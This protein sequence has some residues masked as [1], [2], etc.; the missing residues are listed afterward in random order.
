[1]ASRADSK[2]LMQ[3]W[4]SE[5]SG[6]N[7]YIMFSLNS[8][9]ESWAKRNVRW[10]S[11]GEKQEETIKGFAF[12]SKQNSLDVAQVAHSRLAHKAPKSVS[13]TSQTGCTQLQFYTVR[14]RGRINRV[15]KLFSL[16]QQ[17]WW[18]PELYETL[19]QQSMPP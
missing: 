18:H 2:E 3:K 15:S 16:T 12:K 4:N 19:F 1:M 5:V 14:V 8:W 10:E 17:I 11:S 9:K 7:V 6:G 13:S